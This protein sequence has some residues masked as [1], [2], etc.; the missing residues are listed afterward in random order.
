[1]ARL[2]ANENFP[3]Q[4]VEALR[5]LGHDVLTVQEAGNAGEA[6]GDDQVLAFATERDRAVITVNRRDFIRL[7]ALRPSHGGIVVCSQDPDTD[8]QADRIH[9]AIG[10]VESPAGQLLRV[11]RPLR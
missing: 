11:S 9:Q 4:V 5:A 3:R 8:R 7:H 2:Y 6:I 1:M 10:S